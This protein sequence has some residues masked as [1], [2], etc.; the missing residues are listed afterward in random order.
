MLGR[1]VPVTATCAELCLL[2]MLCWQAVRSFRP[3]VVMFERF[4]VEEMFGWVDPPIRI[5]PALAQTGPCPPKV[6]TRRLEHGHLPHQ[7]IS[8]F[9][10]D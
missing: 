1:W 8:D 9:L 4:N 6:S 7:T 5:A 10:L 3:D 2:S